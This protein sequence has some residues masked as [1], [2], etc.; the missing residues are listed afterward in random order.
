MH[1]GERERG[2]GTTQGNE[3]VLDRGEFEQGDR[4][5]RAARE[6]ADTSYATLLNQKIE[7]SGFRKI[8][9]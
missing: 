7:D 1:A 6:Q 3:E 8:P 2:H 9:R 4:V 5:D